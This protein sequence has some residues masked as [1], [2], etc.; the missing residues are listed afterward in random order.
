MRIDVGCSLSEFKT[1]Y[2]GSGYAAELGLI[3]ER[4]I[5]QEKSHLIVLR[6]DSEIIG[7]AIWHESSTVEHRRG[8][9]RDKEDR[10]LL[11]RLLGG[12]KDLVELHEL[13]L[14]QEYRRKGYGTRFFEFFEGFIRK[15]GY[16][17]IAY[18]ANHPAA[19]AICR[20]RGYKEDFL[21]KEKE[22]VFTLMLSS[23]HF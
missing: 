15:K 18:Y 8:D 19:I 13:W 20:K 6:D 5:T 21:E 16:H 9:K 4:I 17:S 2:K 12:K 7:H 23:S 14:K 1:Y 22:Y 10:Q 3:E 11:E